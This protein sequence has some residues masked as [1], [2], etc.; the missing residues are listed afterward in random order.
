MPQLIP[1]A[2]AAV[3]S[4]YGGPILAAV[5]MVATSA[6][7]GG[8]EQRK[9]A[10]QQ[11]DAYNAA[12]VDRL[13]NVVT[14]ISTRELVL[15]R[16]RKGGGVYFRGSAGDYKT[17]FVMHLTLAAHEIDAVEQIYFDDVPITLNGSDE[18]T[19]EPYYQT[20]KQS[21]TTT[22]AAGDTTA[23]LPS[24]LVAESVY[25]WAGSTGSEDATGVFAVPFTLSGTTVSIGEAVLYPVTVE[26]QTL[27][28]TSY[29]KVWWD[30]GAPGAVADARTKALFPDLWTD[31][32]RGEGVARLICEFTFNETAFPDQR[33]PRVT[34]LIRGAKVYDPRSATTAWTDNPALL[35]R[36]VYQHARF[37]KATISAE[38][39]TRFSAAANACDTSQGWVVDGVTETQAL[40]RAGMV[41]PFGAAAK[42]VFDDLTRA[43]AGMW[44]FAGGQLYV[45]A[46]VYTASVMTL[47]DADLAVIQREE[48]A[49]SQEPVTIAV[50]RERARKFNTVNVRIWDEDQDYKEVGLTPV[51]SSALVT[52]DG[53]ELA[54][55][56]QLSAV[57]YAPQAQHIAGVMMRDA[58][59]A[60]MFE[61]HWKLKAWPLELFDT[62]AVTLARYGWTAKTF[63]VLGRVWDPARGTFK[64]TLKET[65][66][67]IYSPDASFLAQGYATNTALPRPWSIQPP[68]LSAS[69]IESGGDVLLLQADGSVVSRALVTWPVIYDASVRQGGFVDIEWRPASSSNW[70]RVT[71]DGTETQAYLLGVP[72]G[73]AIV[74]RGRTRNAVATSDWSA[75]VGHVVVGKTEAPQDVPWFSLDVETLRWGAVSDVDL[76]GYR[77]RFN[78]GAN[79][80]WQSAAALHEGLLTASPYTLA[81]RPAGLVTFLIKA[82]DTSGNE[83]ANAVAIIKD[84]GDIAVANVIVSYEEAPDFE[85]TITNGSV[86]AGVLEADDTDLFF[87]DD[88]QPFVGIDSDVFFDAS[89][90]EQMVYEWQ[91]TISV[92]GTITLAYEIAAS[93][94]TIEFR[95]DSQDAFFEADGDLFFTDDT[96][97]AFFGSD[98]DWAT[99]PGQIELEGT[100]TL[101]WRITTAGGPT[102]GVITEATVTID[103]PD[104]AE[105]LD[106]IAISAGGTRLPITESYREITNVQLTVQADGSGGISARIADKDADA[107][108]LVYVLDAAGTPVDGLVDASIK[109]Y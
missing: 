91:R 10:R 95:R 20:R 57:T 74:V 31:D 89:T 42:D 85:G 94:F 55:E 61:A 48:D 96:T 33:P 59:D 49:E 37:G 107:G 34:A 67:A 78:Y 29:A 3:A 83:S 87:G 82:V 32:H 35:M 106:D 6:I 50:H 30:L 7:V 4:A 101:Y 80:F 88:N 25:C 77:I 72:D 14:S 54:Q 60:L 44:A 28:A 99:W 47:T 5:T 36:H 23:A 108:P 27:E 26:Y 103:V 1:A 62:V 92:P 56:V 45:R 8:Y 84:L 97:G 70:Q 15:G 100:E 22:I 51:K 16:V 17:T 43:M 2:L 38:E 71:V 9:I 98:G 73:A 39:D 11:R 66:A 52:R 21:R 24:N 93:H 64:L 109:G 86:D 41:V 13:A 19:T 102:Q 76:A 75:Q 65:A 79:R 81:T 69:G 53:A 105:T 68:S 46:G 12:Q 58:R 40:Y 104:V 18:V 90:Y 63:I